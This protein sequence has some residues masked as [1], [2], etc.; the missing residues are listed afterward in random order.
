MNEKDRLEVQALIERRS[1]PIPFSGCWAWD[2][3]SDRDGYGK[4][5]WNGVSRAAHRLSY[6]AFHGV[7]PGHLMVMHS[8][9]VACCVNPA[10]LSLGTSWE[11]T[12]ERT[13]RGRSR[14]PGGKTWSMARG[15]STTHIY[16]RVTG[17]EVTSAVLRQVIG[18]NPDSGEF[19]WLERPGDHGW[20]RKNAGKVAGYLDTSVNYLR[21]GMYGERF[22]AH[23]LAWLFMMGEW[24]IHHVDHI[25][26]DRTDNR[27]NNL[28]S[29]TQ[30]E[31]NHN[32]GLR[33]NNTSGVKGVSWDAERSRWFASIT[34]NGK[35][36]G[37]GRY[38]EFDDA[39]AA[40]K[41]AEAEYHGAFAHIQ[42][43]A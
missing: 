15:A 40:R 5:K 34:V 8:C 10:H 9:D 2:A 6:E 7:E 4:T 39:V 43:T 38:E 26:G 25:N 28:R 17:K 1:I 30:T 22:F 29:A 20:T 31:N 12:R 14:G 16:D 42:G 24:P 18:Y 3:A 11:N 13:L 37:L 33:R 32:V 27:W 36:K 35:S 41:K 19:R 21:I 23:R